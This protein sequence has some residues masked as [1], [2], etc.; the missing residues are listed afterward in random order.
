V[1]AVAGAWEEG[2]RDFAGEGRDVVSA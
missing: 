2:V 1:S